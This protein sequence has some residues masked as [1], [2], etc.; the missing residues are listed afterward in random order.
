MPNLQTCCKCKTILYNANI[1]KYTGELKFGLNN[2]YGTYTFGN[3]N[4]YVG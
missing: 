3:G 2:G 1:D 4:K